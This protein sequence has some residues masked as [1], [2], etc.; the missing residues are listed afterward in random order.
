MVLKKHSGACA[1]LALKPEQRFGYLVDKLFSN[2][3][4]KSRNI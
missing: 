2:F 4:E 1:S 3:S